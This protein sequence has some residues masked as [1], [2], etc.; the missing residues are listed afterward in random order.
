MP[1]LQ[2]LIDEELELTKTAAHRFGVVVHTAEEGLDLLNTFVVQVEGGHFMA[3]A[4]YLSMQKTATLAY[5]SYIR[6]HHAQGQSNIRALIEY[7]ALCAYLLAHPNE[8]V[9]GKGKNNRNGFL[10]PK[11]LSIKAYKWLDANYPVESKILKGIKDRINDSAAHA[12]VY[13]TQFTFDWEASLGD[14]FHGSFFD[15]TQHDEEALYVIVLSRIIVTVIELLGSI[16][17]KH[18]G[19]VLIDDLNVKTRRLDMLTIHHLNKIELIS[20]SPATSR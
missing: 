6:K 4:A 10:P 5:L 14:E 15:N 3:M 16:A 20:G 9:L 12:S 7:A 2:S 1:T 13:M 11:N 8:E 17:A 18:G 19:F